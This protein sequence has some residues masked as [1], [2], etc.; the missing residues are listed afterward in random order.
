M[1]SSV[2]VTGADRGLGRAFVQEFSARGFRVFAGLHE[3]ALSGAPARDAHGGVTEVPLDVTEIESVRA[4]AR[5]VGAR[6]GALDVVI[7]NAGINPDLGIPLPELDFDVVARVLDVNALGPLRVSQ[8]LVP[9]LER[10]E[11][12]LILNV[13]SEAGSLARC[14]R[15]SW[16]GY[17]MSKAA[18]NMQTRILQNDLAARGFRVF[19]VH[20]GWMRTAM[21]SPDAPLAP[22]DS[23]ARIASL[24]LDDDEPPPQFFQ[25]DGSEYP[26]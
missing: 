3:L 9:L 10:G 1:S 7:N 23:A 25:H 11:K 14:G 15:S 22:E 18:L 13:S 4:A 5:V 19:S 12:K 20:P 24:L 8:A 16:F 6:A 17:C 26:W 21:S 2:F